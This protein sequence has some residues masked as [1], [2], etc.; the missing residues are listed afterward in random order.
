ML[1]YSVLFTRYFTL[2]CIPDSSVEVSWIYPTYYTYLYNRL[3]TSVFLKLL[4][5]LQFCWQFWNVGSR[6]LRTTGFR[7]H[8]CIAAYDISIFITR[9]RFKTACYNVIWP[10]NLP[11]TCSPYYTQML[12]ISLV[13]CLK[14]VQER[15]SRF[16]YGDYDTQ[17]AL[18]RI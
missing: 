12:F 3:M 13:E 10:I 8:W 7:R 5:L 1:Y 6:I 2:R 18:L 4:G 17:S 15:G 16:T 9:S 11:S 14:N